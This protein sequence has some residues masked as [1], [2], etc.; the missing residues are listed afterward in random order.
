VMEILF[1]VLAFL[2]LA[3][4]ILG[5]FLPILP[6]PPLAFFSLLFIHW[7]METGFTNTFLIIMG[8]LA[9]IISL[10]DYYFPILG[11]KKLGGSQYGIRGSTIGLLI[12]L[13]L[14]PVL[15]ISL[16]PFGLTG[17]ILCPFLGA[18]VGERWSGKTADEALKAAFGS[19]LGFLA[20]TFIKFIY[21]I[22]TSYFVLKK[23]SEIFF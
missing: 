16:G 19:F 11:T 20:G 13:I 18:W 10:L 6:G 2:F 15:G 3:I 8:I 1:L 5:A 9:V 12:G 21:A 23:T 7:G 22:I 17:I 4:G 14:L